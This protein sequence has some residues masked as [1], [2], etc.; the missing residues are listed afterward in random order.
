MDIQ[1]MTIGD[2]FTMAWPIL[3]LIAPFYIKRSINIHDQRKEEERK[4][5]KEAFD[6]LA[7]KVEGLEK[8]VLV[9]NERVKH[10]HG[11]K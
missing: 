8:E 2:A 3:L 1:N 4:K 9:L 5:K 11:E 7:E 6:A 10:N